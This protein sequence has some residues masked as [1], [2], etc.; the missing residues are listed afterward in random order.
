MDA[1]RT[2][3]ATHEQSIRSWVLIG[4]MGLA[5]ALAITVVVGM[6]T[7]DVV[8]APAP[9]AAGTGVD[10]QFGPATEDFA[11]GRGGLNLAAA[12]ALGF[13]GIA[14]G[15][16]EGGTYAGAIPIGTPDDFTGVRESGAY[17]EAQDGTA[18]PRR[19]PCPARRSC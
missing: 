4:A 14:T 9:A 5:L 8:Q 7:D 15:I 12:E 11:V 17:Y 3:E 18:I 10:T 1:S 16:R 6:N 2:H 13:T 19:G